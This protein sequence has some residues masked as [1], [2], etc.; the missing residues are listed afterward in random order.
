MTQSLSCS[1]KGRQKVFVLAQNQ[2]Y[3]CCRGYPLELDQTMSYSSVLQFWR[4]ENQL[5]DQGHAV[6]SCQ[7]C[8]QDERKNLTSHRMTYGVD[9]FAN[10]IQLIFSNACNQM[11]SYCS[12]KFSST[13]E[14]D[15]KT[16]GNFVGISKSS[17]Q[18]LIVPVIKQINSDY[19][20]EQIQHS[21]N[22]E[23]DDSVELT[24]LGGEP[25]MQIN[26][27][28]QMLELS[29]KKIKKVCVITNLNPPDNKF[30]KWILENYSSNRLQ[31]LISLDSAPKFNH[32]PRAG[33][34]AERFEENL[35][36]LISNNIKFEFLSVFSV[37]NF[38]NLPDYYTWL[39]KNNFQ[40]TLYNL[41]NP[42]CLRA[43]WI[44]TEFSQP[45]LTKIQHYS[46]PD[47]VSE[48]QKSRNQVDLKLLE[49]YNY[50]TQYFER[51]NTDPNNSVIEFKSYDDL[52]AKLDRV[53]GKSDY[54]PRT[55]HA[56]DVEVNEETESFGSS[57]DDPNMDYFSKLAEAE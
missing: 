16:N 48:L 51:T 21:I 46:V 29:N 33:F 11:C 5:L 9:R 24:L 18:N 1:L 44:P 4:Q 57:A 3:S 41:N 31:F 42:D 32:L 52:K 54:K 7:H 26:S 53:L 56:E 39:D 36:L 20:T 35:N 49:Q 27:I 13:W 55:V 30:L 6:E 22:S 37:L 2:A 12:P 43:F 38:F 45:L 34:D 19:W 14:K 25:L 47:F 17:Q 40:H 23:P 50:L 28:K 8:W 15:I 10:D